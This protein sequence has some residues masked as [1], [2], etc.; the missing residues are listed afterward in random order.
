MNSYNTA[1][2]ELR[3]ETGDG[4]AGAAA[5]TLP[6]VVTAGQWHHVATAID[7]QAG[8]ARLFVD[9]AD[10]TASATV[11][12]GF[13]NA[14]ALQLGRFTNGSFYLKGTIDETRVE[15]GLRSANWIWASWQSQASNATWAAYSAINPRPRL[16]WTSSA[17]QIRL[18]WRAD[19]GVFSLVRATNLTPP[20]AWL[21]EATSV[22]LTNNEWQAVLPVNAGTNRFY[23]LQQ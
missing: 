13:E 10:R 17:G 9:G 4:V 15:S 6:N 8:T 12:G 21:P 16:S 18:S 22:S 5:V 11:I 2:Q 20:I 19:A 7:R 23:R 14:A 1:D 3:L